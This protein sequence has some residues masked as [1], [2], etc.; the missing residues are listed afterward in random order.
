ME[1]FGPEVNDRHFV[2]RQA[3]GRL[4]DVDRLESDASEDRALGGSS[5]ARSVSNGG[6]IWP[7]WL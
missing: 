2:F 6:T 3:F 4:E 1:A 7:R 5:S